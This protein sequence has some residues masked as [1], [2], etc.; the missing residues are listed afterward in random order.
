MMTDGGMMGPTMAEAAVTAAEKAGSKPR[1][2]ISRISTVPRPAASACATPDMPAK[3]RL[4]ATLTCARPPRMWPTSAIANS[5]IR[6]AMPPEFS[7]LP[8]S[9]NSGMASSG[10]LSMPDVMR[11]TTSDIG[12][13]E[14]NSSQPSAAAISAKATG[15]SMAISPNSSRNRGRTSLIV[16]LPR[17]AARHHRKQA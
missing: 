13:G 9:T 16:R 1:R 4:A 2:R 7:R 10:K 5:K 14:K 15:T 8:A 3:T 11:C 12:T 17:R 6:E